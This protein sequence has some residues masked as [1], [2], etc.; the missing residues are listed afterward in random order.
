MKDGTRKTDYVES[1]FL[2]NFTDTDA[3]RKGGLSADTDIKVINATTEVLT[4][5]WSNT[6]K[7]YSNHP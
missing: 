5:S 3:G 1:A 2:V 7:D 6:I 4:P